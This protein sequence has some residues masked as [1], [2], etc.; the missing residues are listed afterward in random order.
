MKSQFLGTMSH[1]IRTPMNGIIGMTDLLLDTRLTPEQHDYAESVRACSDTLMSIIDDILDF[2][3]ID[4]CTLK[5][6]RREFQPRLILE[7]TLDHLAGRAQAKDLKLTRELASDLP[8]LLIGDP[9]RLR[10]MLV[11][12]IGN[13]IKFTERGEV[14]VAAKVAEWTATSV[15]LRISIHDTGIGIRLEEQ[16]QLF[17][18]FYQTD[19]S[20]TRRYPGSW[21]AFCPCSRPPCPLPCPVSVP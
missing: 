11:I 18:A 7:S 5:L 15:A 20:S 14:F 6:Q 19:G 8:E 13:A 16:G 9:A 3:K 17:Q 2:A 4:A 21:S 10:Q 1:E 12:L